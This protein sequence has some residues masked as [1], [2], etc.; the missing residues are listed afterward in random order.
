M[1]AERS[2][3]DAANA[4]QGL[5]LEVL[6]RYLDPRIGLAGPL[7][8]TL[9]QGGRSNLT[10]RLTDGVSEW[11]L[12]RPPLG[13]V[14]PTAHDMGREY[15][16]LTGLRDTDVPVPSPVHL[17][18]D[19][20]VLGCPFY[21]MSWVEGP[22]LR[23]AEDTTELPHDVARTAAMHLVDTLATLHAA[24]PSVL[25]GMGR[26]DGYMSRQVA[27]WRSQWELSATR[28]LPEVGL[29]ADRLAASV[30]VPRSVGIVHGDYRLDNVI[31][32]PGYDGVAAVIDWEMAT[33]GDPLADLGLLLVY[34]DPVTESVTGSTHAVSANPGFPHRSALLERYAWASGGQLDDLAFYV[35]FGY[36]KLAV[37]A[38]GIHSRYL[39]GRTVGPGFERVGGVV[40]TLVSAGLQQLKEPRA[41]EGP[42]PHPK[43]EDPT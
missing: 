38:E 26:P 1:D 24:P 40:A 4:P 10:Y 34:W 14:L 19:D 17:C 32:R 21:L 37:I 12:R 6:R 31:L 3:A 33:V 30:P 9:I 20:T 8:A 25:S 28:E 15:R 42:V 35:A 29:L 27:R 11:V 5:D 7:R 43:S 13:N 23:D 22:V 2:A 41:I 16:V 36:F 39:A 18:D